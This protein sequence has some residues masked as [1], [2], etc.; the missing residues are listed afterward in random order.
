MNLNERDRKIIWHPLTQEKTSGLPI[1]IKGA[2]GSY[3]Y[4]ENNK[5]YLD[6]ISSW[7][8]NL[9]GHAHPNI[10]K[11]IYDQSMTLEHII[12]A[13]FTHEP[14]VQLCEKLQSLLPDKFSKFFFSDN[15]STA[16]EVALKMAYQCWRNQGNL[17]RTTFLSFDGGY[18][19]DTFGAMSVGA[20]SG[21]HDAFL[22][23][24]FSV[25]T[26]PFP[27]TWDGDE[28]IRSKETYA[29]EVLES[30]L[31]TSAD[32]IAALILEPLVQG[33]SGMRMCSSNFVSKVVNLVRQYEI[34]V[35]FDEVMT[36]FGRTGTYFAFE[37]TQVIPDFLCLSKGLTGG[38]LP[39]S[40]TV[41]TEEVYAAFFD[42]KFN[43][44]FAHGHSYTANPL[45]CAAA[46]ASLDLL[47]KPSTMKSIQ[48]IH[49]THRKELANLLAKHTRVTSTIAAFDV[50]DTQTLKRKC[51]E[52]G[53]LIRP[54]G[55]SVYL[56]PPYSTSTS[57]LE[58]A[59]EKIRNI[60]RSL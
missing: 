8:V 24:F 34:L 2:R 45:G 5:P 26:I 37:Q 3:L 43:K 25:L 50:H 60:L 53:L 54:L 6:L 30:H 9:H 14:A 52:Q 57:E 55:N 41:T 46:I 49:N 15:G 31:R 27:E 51:L 20:K 19:G 39:L 58:E 22:D 12:F 10:A 7:W 16:I 1:A 38:F 40:L 21:F 44:A 29:L 48:E 33:A 59:Y 18:H 36:G 56:L 42:E 35:I 23:L 13:G 47:V 17:E 4:D 11:A 28:E 32:K